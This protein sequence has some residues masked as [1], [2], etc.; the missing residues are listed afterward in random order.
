MR[1][2]LAVLTALLLVASLFLIMASTGLLPRTKRALA[3][4]G[5][6][7]LGT[8]FLVEQSREQDY[9]AA[10]KGRLSI[11]NPL[12]K[13]EV[14]GTDGTE[15][16]L[17]AVKKAKAFS[18]AGTRRLLDHIAVEIEYEQENTKI[19]A[20]IPK[21]APRE[22][23]WIDLFLEIPTESSLD[24]HARLGNITVENI[25][26]DLQVLSSLGN[27]EVSDFKGNAAIEASQGDLNLKD[28]QFAEELIAK[29]HL[30]NI[31]IWGNLARAN[32]LTNNL[33]NVNIGLPEDQS[34]LLEGTINL[35]GFSS[36]IPF[37]GRKTKSLIQGIIGSGERRGTLAV[38]LDLGSLSFEAMK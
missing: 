21:T 28:C 10:L 36:Q 7:R 23:A 11:L 24:L 18:L 30:G 19:T 25:K 9:T 27:V 14:I 17:K 1:K 31:E 4:D 35:G 3:P 13:I 5:P 2:L 32:V 22:Q 29:A 8:S 6:N 38:Q 37:Q 33:G 34:Y 15:I 16:T 26:G 20:Q 12:G